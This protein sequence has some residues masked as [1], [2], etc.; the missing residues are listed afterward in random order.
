MRGQELRGVQRILLE[1]LALAPAHV[2]APAPSDVRLRLVGPSE[3]DPEDA[4]FSEELLGEPCS[5]VEVHGVLTSRMPP[6]VARDES[7]FGEA[8]AWRLSREAWCGS[9]GAGGCWRG[10]REAG[11]KGRGRESCAAE[12]DVWTAAAVAAA[13][14]A[15]ATAIAEGV[16]P[17][18]DLPSRDGV[19]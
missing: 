3:G 18:V 5:A 13:L 6:W 17:E 2:E 7:R 15:A 19:W 10:L 8:Q 11:V 4:R 14:A 9:S 12:R 16:V 1:V